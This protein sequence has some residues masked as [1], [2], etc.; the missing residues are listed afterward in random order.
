[1]K[2]N[3]SC[4][5]LFVM[6]NWMSSIGSRSRGITLLERIPR[7]VLIGLNDVRHITFGMDVTYPGGRMF[8][9]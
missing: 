2:K 1:M 8:T 5:L 7:L 4:V 3:C 6:K 9:Q